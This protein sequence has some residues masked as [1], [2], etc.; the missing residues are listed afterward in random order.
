MKI[1]ITL[2]TTGIIKFD[3][4]TRIRND[5]NLPWYNK[6]TLLGLVDGGRKREEELVVLEYEAEWLQERK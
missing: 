4:D 2:T 1:V 5:F 3:D 6:K